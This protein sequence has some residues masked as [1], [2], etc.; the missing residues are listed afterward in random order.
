[1]TRR[2]TT[3]IRHLAPRKAAAR[4]IGLIALPLC[5]LLWASA[6][7]AADDQAGQKIAESTCA[8]CH[9]KDYQTPI[10]PSYPRLAGQFDDYL[11]KA[12]N[13]YQSGARKNAIMDGIAKPLSKADIENVAAYLS[14]L[15]G[16]LTQKK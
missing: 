4:K 10:D 9:G 3:M 11:V 8:A 16:P 6:A 13:D 14:Q 1:M 7:S 2:E 5:G 15:P 12:L